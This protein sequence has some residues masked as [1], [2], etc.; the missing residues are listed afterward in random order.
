MHLKIQLLFCDRQNRINVR[1]YD[2]NCND[3]KNESLQIVW[4]INERRS[5]ELFKMFAHFKKQQESDS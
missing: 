4:L 1:E 5:Y 2:N 3:L